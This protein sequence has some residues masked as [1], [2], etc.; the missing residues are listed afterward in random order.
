[1]A[2]LS[3]GT[4]YDE[5]TGEDLPKQGVEDARRDEMEFFIKMGVYEHAPIEE[6]WQVTGRS[7]IDVKW[8]DVRK[9]DGRLRSR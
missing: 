1:M 7:P 4:Y 5:L 8:V 3:R 2:L 6:A 9:S